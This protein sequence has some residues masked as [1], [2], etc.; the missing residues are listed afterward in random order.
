MSEEGDT[1]RRRAVA[2]AYREGDGAPRV[3][4]K[5][6]GDVAER[7]VEEARRHGVF[8]HAAPEL[9]ALLMTVNLDQRIPEALYQVVAELLVWVQQLE[10]GPP[11]E[12]R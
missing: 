9:V 12:Q 6:Y 2:L 11:G 10:Q 5:G 8:V 3:M 7:L 1:S 4:A